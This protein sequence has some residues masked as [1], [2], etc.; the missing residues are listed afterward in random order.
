[1]HTVVA[2]LYLCV[3][4]ITRSVQ[5]IDLEQEVEMKWTGSNKDHYESKGYTFTK[6]NKSFTVRA[7]DLMP[8]S[9][10][11]VDVRCELCNN[12]ISVNYSN[13]NRAIRCSGEF[14][15][16][17]CWDT[18][19]RARTTKH[20]LDEA[21]E[22]FKYHGYT[23]TANEY[24]DSRT[25]MEYMCESHGIQ[26]MS[27]DNMARGK[28]C[29]QCSSKALSGE[30]HHNWKGGITELNNYLRYLL[31]P[32]ISY[33]LKRVN[34][35]CELT[36]QQGI[37][38]VHH[39]YSFK[40]IIQDTMKELQLN[41]KPSMSDYSE[42]ELQL[43]AINFVKNNDLY[44]K[45]IVMLESVHKDFHSFCGGNHEHTSFEQLEQFKAALAS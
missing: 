18:V 29:P 38:N 35:R 16:K 34:Y 44:S 11:K 22:L 36:G 13:Y 3:L 15:C 41:I 28:K 6:I 45:P 7:E 26:H 24:I 33:H 8:G 39:M 5:M 30:N 31:H 21:R 32:W 43:I 10:K 23:L 42:D 20:N 1:M 27:Y 2:C 17:P 37:L 9:D 40:S 12:I 19:K 14:C 4:E 25:P